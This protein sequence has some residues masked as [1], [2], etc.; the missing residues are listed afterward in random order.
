MTNLETRHRKSV[1]NIMKPLIA[2]PSTQNIFLLWPNLV[3]ITERFCNFVSPLMP[4]NARNGEPLVT[5]AI[6]SAILAYRQEKT[7]RLK[8]RA[9]VM[10]LLDESVASLSG[11]TVH[12]V[13]SDLIITW[14]PFI[15]PMLGWMAKNNIMTIRT[16]RDGKRIDS[17][18]TKIALLVH[19]LT[20][21][22]M[23]DMG[24]R[25]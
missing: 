21:Q 19:L 6:Q 2:D 3:G 5:H 23:E 11:M 22:E 24:F 15:E 16:T 9:Y 25:K 1:S 10:A 7:E 4:S 8:G 12:G 13:K 14:E 18:T 20:A 17:E